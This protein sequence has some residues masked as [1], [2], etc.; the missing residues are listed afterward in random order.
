MERGIPAVSRSEFMATGEIGN[1]RFFHVEA[2]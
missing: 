2:A 1:A